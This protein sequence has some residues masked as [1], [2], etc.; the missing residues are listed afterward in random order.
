[1]HR[2][3]PYEQVVEPVPI[4]A[5]DLL[6]LIAPDNHVVKRAFEFDPRFPRHAGDQN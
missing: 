6:P 2:D 4:V 1:M 3:G 5:N